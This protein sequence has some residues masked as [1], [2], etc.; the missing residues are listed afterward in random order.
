MLKVGSS[1]TTVIIADE[2][3]IRKIAEVSGDENPIHLD[4][5]F[6]YNSKFGRRI[7]H[8]LFC[9]N[10]I[11]MIIGN[12]LPGKGSVLI[13]QN[14]KYKKP[15]YI[16]DST[17]VK[18]TVI[19]CIPECRYILRTLCTNQMDEIVLDGESLVSWKDNCIE[20]G[21]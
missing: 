16:G 12:H 14:F 10:A 3:I 20:E 5:V 9:I 18:V 11:S 7:A 4:E 2:Q 19:E 17:E 15:V 8:G 13:S 21:V 1:Y 6:K